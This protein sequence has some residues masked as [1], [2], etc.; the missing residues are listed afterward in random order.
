MLESRM[1]WSD[2]IRCHREIR[3]QLEQWKGLDEEKGRERKHEWK[4]TG[5]RRPRQWDRIQQGEE[6][7]LEEGVC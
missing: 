2:L 3:F 4:K 6:Q 5:R 7:H 1:I